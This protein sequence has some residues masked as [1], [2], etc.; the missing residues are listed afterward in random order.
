MRIARTFI[1][2]SELAEFD[3]IKLEDGTVVLDIEEIMSSPPTGVPAKYPKM[4]KEATGIAEDVANITESV[5]GLGQVL[6]ALAQHDPTTPMTTADIAN[7]A[8]SV[9]PAPPVQPEQ[10]GSL[11]KSK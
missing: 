2:N 1:G 3:G 6:V 8:G 7:A 4:Q 5:N 9:D 11:M 10:F